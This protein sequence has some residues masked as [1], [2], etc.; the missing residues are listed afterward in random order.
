MEEILSS[1]WETASSSRRRAPRRGARL[2]PPARVADGACD[3]MTSGCRHA[4]VLPKSDI[5][6]G[7]TCHRGGGRSYPFEGNSYP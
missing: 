1:L 6:A 2:A 3:M 7:G 5:R 4:R